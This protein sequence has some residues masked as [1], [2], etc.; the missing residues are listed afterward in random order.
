MLGRPLT[1]AVVCLA[2]LVLVAGAGISHAQSPS[3]KSDRRSPAA[4]ATSSARIGTLLDQA[5]ASDD[6]DISV[7]VA[8]GDETTLSSQMAGKIKKIHFGLGESVAVGAVILEFD[9][10][11]QEAQLQSAE[12]EYRG[13]RETHLTKMRLQALGAAGE[14]EVTVAAAATDKAKSQV[15]LRESQMAFCRVLSPFAGR[16]VKVRVK[17]AESVPIGQPLL[18]IV[19]PNSLKAQLYV[20][21]SWLNWV[22]PGTPL[23]V[24]TDGDNRGH[25]ARISKLNG[26]IEGVSQTLELEAKFDGPTKGLLPG[27]VGTAVFPGRPNP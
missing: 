14:L 13:A 15:S 22:K 19:N 11:E 12:A 21:A 6:K 10:E 25:R 17:T 23:I 9:C 2:A 24:K 4:P 8:S 3:T 18:E 20:P 16:V 7:L 26:R 27:M 5:T 1:D